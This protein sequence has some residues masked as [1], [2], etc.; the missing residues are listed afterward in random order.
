LKIKEEF[1]GKIVVLDIRGDLMQIDDIKIF[2]EKVKQLVSEGF[3]KH[4]YNLSH[5]KWM[6]S[7]GLG[8]LMSSLVTCKNAGGDAKIANA[9]DK[10]NSLLMITKLTKIYHNYDSIEKALASYKL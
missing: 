3:T 4:I 6:N 1:H 2:R 8:S 7:S 9:T 10:I 5:V